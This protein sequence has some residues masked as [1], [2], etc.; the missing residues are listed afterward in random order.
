MLL[1]IRNFIVDRWPQGISRIFIAL[2][3]WL[4]GKKKKRMSICS[5][6]FVICT[7]PAT[8]RCVPIF[9]V[10]LIISEAFLHYLAACYKATKTLNN[11]KTASGVIIEAVP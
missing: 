1:F 10:G 3:F 5:V 7:V 6:A 8:L 11:A 9:T 4:G 2:S